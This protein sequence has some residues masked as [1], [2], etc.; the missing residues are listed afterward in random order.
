MSGGQGTADCVFCKIAAGSIP[1]HRLYED[2]RTLAFLDINPATRGHA[3]AIPKALAPDLISSADGDLAA[4]LATTRRV[5]AAIVATVEPDGFNLLQANGPGAAQSVL[6][7]HLHIVPRYAGDELK[8]NW[9]LVPG[10][11]AAL[12]ALAADIRLAMR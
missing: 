8:M 1:C 10:D 7:F 11:Q 2:A 6:H 4:V 9:G 12:A 3:L 5:A